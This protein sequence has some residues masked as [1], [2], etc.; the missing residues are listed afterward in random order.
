MDEKEC[1]V[2]CQAI[3]EYRV[4]L[5][6]RKCTVYA[7]RSL[8]WLNSIKASDGRLAWRSLLLQFYSFNV[9]Y[10]LTN[11]NTNAEPIY[12]RRNLPVSTEHIE[13]MISLM[14]AYT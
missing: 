5:A 4:Y 11:A 3:T 8:H 6:N 9:F 1:L 12:R 13:G 10:K 2:D 14:I 7:N